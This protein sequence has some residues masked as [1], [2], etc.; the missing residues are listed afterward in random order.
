MGFFSSLVDPLTSAFNLGIGKG[1]SGFGETMNKITGVYGSMDKSYEQQLKSMAYQ[2]AYNTA[3]WNKQNEYNSPAAQL[4]RMREA[5]IDIN[6]TS[7][8]LG[9]GNLSNTSAFVG[10]ENGFAGSGSPA[11]NP[12]SMA[13]GV[14]NGISE[15]R[16]RN[17]Y[18]KNIEAQTKNLNNFLNDTGR[19]TYDPQITKVVED[20]PGNVVRGTKNVVKAIDEEIGITDKIA[21]L[22]SWMNSAQRI[23]NQNVVEDFV[24]REMKKKKK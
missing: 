4:A 9:T 11:G 21:S 1:G 3:M 22:L 20:L 17:A 14:A 6:P 2:N 12:I 19:S 7:Y 24:A 23:Q 16:N 18:T 8:A 5:G 13:L 15:V 10:S